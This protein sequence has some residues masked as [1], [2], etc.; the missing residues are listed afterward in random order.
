MWIF[1]VPSRSFL[2]HI[3]IFHIYFIFDLKNSTSKPKKK[4]IASQSTLATD[5]VNPKDIEGPVQKHIA[6]TMTKW[7]VDYTF[8]CTGSTAV[9]RS[10]LECAHRGWGVSCVIGVAASGHEISTR[11]FQLVTGRVWKGKF[12]NSI[13]CNSV[14]QIIFLASNG[15]L[16]FCQFQ[17]PLSVDSSLAE[18]FPCWWTSACAASCQWT[19]SSPIIS[20]ESERPMRP[21]QLCIP[22]NAYALSWST[23]KPFSCGV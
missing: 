4:Q 8:D 19:T 15:R 16:V 6:G 21:S 7:G 18:I 2:F 9:M 22:G 5:F 1:V 12:E 10:A 11:P 13:M 20:K 17:E 14:P 23:S 3:R